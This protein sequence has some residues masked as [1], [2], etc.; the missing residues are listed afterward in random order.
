MDGWNEQV[1]HNVIAVVVGSCALINIWFLYRTKPYFLSPGMK[2]MTVGMVFWCASDL[3]KA[4]EIS[5]SII[6][7]DS[8]AYPA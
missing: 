7:A 6:G 8:P 5:H 2:L 3:M 4:S 1:F